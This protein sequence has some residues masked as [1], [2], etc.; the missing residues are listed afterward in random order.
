AE[1]EQRLAAAFRMNSSIQRDGERVTA[2]EIRFMAQELEGALGGLY[3]ILALE[4]QLPMVRL[5]LA[6]LERRKKIP[7][8]PSD[9]VKPQ[10]TT[11]IE[12]LGRGMEL[13]RLAQF[14]KFLEP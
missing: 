7:A 6:N 8:L 4:L 12:A 14:L 1:L 5:I 3:S 10:I 2:E 13:N 9:K 11:G